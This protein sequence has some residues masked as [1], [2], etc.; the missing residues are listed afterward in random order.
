M[1]RQKSACSRYLSRAIADQTLDILADEGRRVVAARLEAV[2]YRR[3]GFEQKR[4]TGPYSVLGFLGLLARAMSLQEPTISSGSP[5]SSRIRCC[6][7]LTQ[8]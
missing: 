2:D 4:K 8:R 3:R 5:F 1:L 7:S 6:S